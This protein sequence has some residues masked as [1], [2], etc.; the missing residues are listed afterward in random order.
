[1][2]RLVLLLSTA[3][4]AACSSS[5]ST[6]T[7]STSGSTSAAGGTTTAA[8]SSTTAASASSTTGHSTTNGGSTGLSTAGSTGGSTGGTSAGS[9]SGGSTGGSTAGSTSGGST[10]TSGVPSGCSFRQTTTGTPPSNDNCSA[11]A[12]LSL[13]A[14][15]P[16]DTTFAQNDFA[17]PTASQSCTSTRNGG[18]DVV[19]SFTPVATGSFT[20]TVTPQTSADGGQWDPVIYLL[21]TCPTS[22]DQTPACT[23][24]ADSFVDGQPVSLNFGGTAN[25]TSFIIVD[26]WSGISGPFGGPFTIDVTPYVDAGQPPGP[27]AGPPPANDNCE[28]LDAGLDLV[29][30]PEPDGGQLATVAFD[31]TSYHDDS[32]TVAGGQCG[33]SSH[34]YGG[35]EVFHLHLAG[36][37]PSVTASITAGSS[38]YTPIVYIRTS[39][40]LDLGNSHDGGP[41]SEL[42]CGYFTDGGAPSATA[43]NLS[44]GDYYIWADGYGSQGPGT[45]TVTVP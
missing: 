8:G 24:G 5:S 37:V 14:T 2:K 32:Q 38:S 17:Y 18:P 3:A 10:G 28:S 42:A 7:S 39:P 19:Y 16:G 44:A 41:S 36:A 13:N 9:T 11:P 23:V 40:C 6:S 27:D 35:D 4:L 43:T 26:H 25:T 33:A 20:V 22:C 15:V 12:P 29:L 34:G 30:A 1:M 31:T 21:P 45:L